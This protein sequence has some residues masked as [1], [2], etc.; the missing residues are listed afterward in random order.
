MCNLPK[1]ILHVVGAMNAAGTETMLMNIYRNIDRNKIQFDFISYQANGH[2]DEEIKK[3]GGRIINLSKTLSVKEL[4]DAIQNYGPFYAVHCH[5]LFHCGVAVFAAKLAG[6]RLRISHSHTTFDRSDSFHRKMYMRLMRYAINRFSTKLLA[7]SSQA[8]R[9]LFGDNNLNFTYFPNL[10]DY[11]QFLK[12]KTAEVNRFKMEHGLMDSI[13]IGHIGRFTDAKN[14][15]FLLEILQSILKKETNV[16]LLLVGD[17]ELKPQI[18]GLA[19]KL[20][21]YEKI[22]FAGIRTDVP[23][24]LNCMDIFVFPSLH[25]GLGLVLLEAQAA[26]LPCVVSEAIQSEADLN[27]NLVS[28]LFLADGADVWADKILEMAGKKEKDIDKIIK[29]FEDNQYSLPAGVA[30]LMNIYNITS[31]VI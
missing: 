12:K 16:K 27:I 30:K 10:I 15:L 28:K 21:I 31:E 11:R 26:G 25:E 20:G 9:Y 19:R 23:L 5:T 29:G 18:I 17:G 22:C 14:H 8:G 13:V 4:Y 7:C 1:R 3:L 6:V 2:Y 24:I